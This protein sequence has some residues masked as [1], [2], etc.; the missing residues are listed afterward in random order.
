MTRRHW[1]IVF[2]FIIPLPLGEF[3]LFFDKTVIVPWLDKSVV[4]RETI[5]TY[6]DRTCDLL[7]GIIYVGMSFLFIETRRIPLI[8]LGATLAFV[9][10][11]FDFV[12]YL[13]NRNQY[14]SYVFMFSCSSL[15]TMVIYWFNSEVDEIKSMINSLKEKVEPKEVHQ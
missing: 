2:L 1:A 4:Y 9:Y 10:V 12:M 15:I 6:V 5:Q 13:V 11:C 3:Y 8:K 7:I 14:S